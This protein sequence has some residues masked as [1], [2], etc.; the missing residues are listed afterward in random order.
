MNNIENLKVLLVNAISKKVGNEKD[1]SL[2][3]SGGTD[4]LTCLF[5]CFELDIK[6]TLHTFYLENHI[7]EDYIFSKKIAE[8]YNLKL[9]PTIIKQDKSQLCFD[10]FNLIQTYGIYNKIRIQIIYPFL[11]IFPNI[12][13]SKV[14]TGLSADTLYGT[15]YHSKMKFVEEFSKIRNYAIQNDEID[16]CSTLISMAKKH[17]KELIVP[18]R[19]DAVMKY[20]LQ[21]SWNELNEPKQKKLSYDA[22]DNYFKDLNLNRPSCSLV[23]NSKILEWFPML[24]DSKLNQHNRNTIDEIFSDIFHN[25]IDKIN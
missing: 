25:R 7:S 20:F 2:L 9:I 11:H 23:I 12:E 8:K 19:D 17:Q 24:L 18:Y 6:P 10:I 3:F 4:S 5:S 16:G 15:N 14:I 13:E 22:F 21:F 1:I